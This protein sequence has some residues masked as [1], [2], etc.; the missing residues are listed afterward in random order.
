M[1]K[2][3]PLINY[4]SPITTILLFHCATSQKELYELLIIS[5]GA[6]HMTDKQVDKLVGASDVISLEL[7]M[8]INSP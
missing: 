1:N 4:N 3:G 6:N 8:C 2:N 7:G 5:V